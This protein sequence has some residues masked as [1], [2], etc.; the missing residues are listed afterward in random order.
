MA[1]R[2]PIA[3]RFTRETAHHRMTVLHDDGLY[4]HLHFADANPDP[5]KRMSWNLWFDLITVPGALIFQGDGESFTFRRTE[6]M[7][8]FFLGSAWKGEPN[9]H[10][11]S[12]KLTNGRDSVMRYSEAL[13][14]DEVKRAFIED[15][16]NRDVPPGTGKALIEHFETVDHLFESEA[17]DALDS[18]E[19]KGYR[20]H[21]KWEWEFSE[22]HWWFR[23]ACHAIV[24]GVAQYVAGYT[25]GPREDRPAAAEQPPTLPVDAPTTVPAVVTVATT[26]DFL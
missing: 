5:A 24:W 9:Y 1:D 23:W 26:G 14:I 18:F 10:Y 12:E 3:D 8:A 22:Y 11:W 17:R 20:L 25:D 21:D 19:Y 16:R 6:D 7:F 15:V 2:D 4:R 13:F